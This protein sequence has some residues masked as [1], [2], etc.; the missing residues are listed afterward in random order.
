MGKKCLAP[1]ILK[2]VALLLASSTITIKFLTDCKYWENLLLT[3]KVLI[4]TAAYDI[5]IFFL[6]FSETIRLDVSC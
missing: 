1:C 6:N 5:L 3:L 2:H 4:T